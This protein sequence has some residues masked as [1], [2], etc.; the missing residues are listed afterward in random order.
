VVLLLLLF[1]LPVMLVL[2]FAYVSSAG[3]ARVPVANSDLISD[4]DR[5]VAI[6]DLRTAYAD[7]RLELAE[8]EARVHAAWRAR[9]RRELVRELQGLR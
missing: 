6:A 5:V 7:G 4:G 2:A 8:F 9:R 1:V 3:P